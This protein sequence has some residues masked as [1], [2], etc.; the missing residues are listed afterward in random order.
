MIRQ[1][2]ILRLISE[3]RQFVGAMIGTGDPGR[4]GE[5][6]HAVLH[7][8][9]RLFQCPPANFLG[10]TIDQQVEQLGRDESPETAVEKVATY[11]ATLEQA[12]RIYEA[13]NRDQLAK[14][15]RQIALG[16][17]LIATNRWPEQRTLMA[18]GITTLRQELAAV[19]LHPHVQ[20]LLDTWAAK[21]E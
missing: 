13:T 3:L 6:L 5:A 17:L 10:L 21:P 12:A 14:N 2:Y 7:A 16:S 18:D 20:E 19:E 8:Q 11:A 4:A 15:S 1:D 9:E